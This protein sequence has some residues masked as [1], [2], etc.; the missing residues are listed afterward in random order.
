MSFSFLS[1]IIFYK[2]LFVLVELEWDYKTITPSDFSVEMEISK[3]QFVNFQQ[4]EFDKEAYTGLSLGSAFKL[5]LL[6]QLPELIQT[7]ILENQPIYTQ[8]SETADYSEV[9]KIAII[10]FAYENDDL[11]KILKKRGSFI[12]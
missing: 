10:K 9:L 12:A 7:D 4:Q 6:K 8:F 3:E 2:K 5:F 1:S 11:I